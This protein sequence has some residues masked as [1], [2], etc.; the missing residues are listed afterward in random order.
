MGKI[1]RM[2]KEK[3]RDYMEERQEKKMGR[4]LENKE[5]NQMMSKLEI[6]C[7]YVRSQLIPHQI[8]CPR[9]G[10]K[11]LPPKMGSYEVG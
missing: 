11:I 4:E 5:K 2:L 8:V 1:W 10:S 6:N 9:C 3:K 7:F